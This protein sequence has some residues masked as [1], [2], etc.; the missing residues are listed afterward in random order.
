MTARNGA[1]TASRSIHECLTPFSE[2]DRT[3][4]CFIGEW[5]NAVETARGW[6]GDECVIDAYNG[7]IAV[8]FVDDPETISGRDY[9][10][11]FH[12]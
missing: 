6:N 8:R 1:L 9:G 12:P 10:S 2:V 4:L 7:G 3:R 5:M 11:S